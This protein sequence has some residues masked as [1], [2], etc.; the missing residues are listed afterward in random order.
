MVEV[1]ATALMSWI[2]PFFPQKFCNKFCNNLRLS[3]RFGFP[4]QA[5]KTAPGA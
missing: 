2:V 4:G 3:L 1:G 5:I